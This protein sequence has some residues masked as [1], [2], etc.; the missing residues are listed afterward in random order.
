MPCQ[1]QTPLSCRA[2]MDPC[3][4]E[5]VTLPTLGEAAAPATLTSSPKNS[6]SFPPC[7]EALAAF[8]LASCAPPAPGRRGGPK[9]P[10]PHPAQRVGAWGQCRTA[11]GV[12]RRSVTEQRRLSGQSGQCR[13]FIPGPLHLPAHRGQARTCEHP[14]H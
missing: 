5:R 8:P 6:L 2:L 7:S 10:A 4:W 9:V 12:F 11:G 1:H 14:R 3:A 13:I